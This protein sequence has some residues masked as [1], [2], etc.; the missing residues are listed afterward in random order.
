MPKVP[1]SDSGSAR[2]GMMVARDR[3]QEQVDH[4]HDEQHAEQQGELHVADG[5]ADRRRAVADERELHRARQR[6]FKLGQQ[7]ASRGSAVATML[8]PGWRW[9]EST[10]AGRPL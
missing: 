6:L 10:T 3:A 2:P 9:I 7:P 4:Q 5:G 8:A 1:M